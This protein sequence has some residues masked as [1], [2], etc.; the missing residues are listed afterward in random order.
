MKTYLFLFSQAMNFMYLVLNANIKYVCKCYLYPKNVCL[1]A[2]VFQHASNNAILYMFFTLICIY[3]SIP[4][5]FSSFFFS[6]IFRNLFH[7]I[8][9]FYLLLFPFPYSE[10]NFAHYQL[11]FR[12]L[13]TQKSHLIGRAPRRNARIYLKSNFSYRTLS[14]CHTHIYIM[15]LVLPLKK[16]SGYKGVAKTRNEKK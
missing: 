10:A 4:I 3:H 16:D 11:Y 12:G 9:I 14:R 1:E 15:Q 13:G 8:Y 7:Y 6:N 2:Y 5:S